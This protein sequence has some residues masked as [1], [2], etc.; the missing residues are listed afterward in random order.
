[1]HGH[2]P[3]HG[4]LPAAPDSRDRDDR[5]GFFFRDCAAE[6][7]LGRGAALH[8]PARRPLRAAPGA[9]GD[10]D[11][12]CR[13]P[14]GDGLVEQRAGPRPGG[15]LTGIGISGTAFGVL[16]GVVARATPLARRSQT[17]GLVAAAGSLGTML[18]APLGAGADRRPWLAGGAGG[19]RR[20]RRVHG[21]AVVRDPRPRARGG[22]AAARGA[23]ERRLGA[24]R[25]GEASRL[26]RHDGGVLRLRLPADLPHHA[27]AAVP[28]DLRRGAGR[29]REGAGAD[30]PVQHGGHVV[31]RAARRALQPEAAPRADLPAAHDRDLRVPAAAGHR[32]HHAGVRRDRLPLAR[33]G[34]AR[35]RPHRPGV[36]DGAFRRDVRHRL[37][38]PPARLVLRRVDGR[39][40]VRPHRRVLHRL[41]GADRDRVARLHAAVDDGRSSAAAAA[42]RR[43]SAAGG[44]AG[45]SVS[46]RGR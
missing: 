35:H 15:F 1:M 16:M 13:G 18:I 25:D 44:D 10:V 2:A 22:R 32:G 9:P 20:H 28:R 5:G 38:Q 26:C 33:R 17:V 36:R 3:E 23:A 27:P 45:L 39:P 12:L 19:V 40:G 21:A 6:H 29:Q 14:A 8:R 43:R 4:P 41:G 7:R 34:A 30:R 46:A 31:L 37:P 24:A 42:P 11:Q